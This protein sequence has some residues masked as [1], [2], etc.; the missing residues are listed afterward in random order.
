MRKMCAVVVAVVVGA[1]SL[2]GAG[3]AVAE[4]QLD[5][6]TIPSDNF[7]TVGD[8]ASC[9]GALHVGA[10]APKG[11]RGTV[12]ITVTSY[13]FVGNGAGWAKNPKCRFLLRLTQWSAKYPLGRET[14]HPV[15]FGPKRGEKFVRDLNPGSGVGSFNV[16][17]YAINSPVQIPQSYGGTGFVAMVS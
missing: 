12:R 7:G 17:S 15:A 11:K 14:F 3:S 13:G 5:R 8:H 4:P 2:L 9:R 16:A 1:L 6:I 10:I